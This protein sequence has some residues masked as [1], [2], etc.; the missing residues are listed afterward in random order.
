MKYFGFNPT[1]I[2][3]YDRLSRMAHPASGSHYFFEWLGI[4]G[5]YRAIVESDRQLDGDIVAL[6]ATDRARQDLHIPYFPDDGVIFITRTMEFCQTSTEYYPNVLEEEGRLRFHPTFN[7]NPSPSR[8]HP[9]VVFYPTAKQH[10]HA[11]L[12][13]ALKV[14]D[15]CHK[16]STLL[17]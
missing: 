12:V 13:A 10:F 16:E 17:S 2:N 6:S 7:L 1:K 8:D 4:P 14:S 5:G 11:L 3:K 15:C 9:L